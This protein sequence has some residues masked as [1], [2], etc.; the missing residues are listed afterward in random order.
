M[1]TWEVALDAD[2][3]IGLLGTF[4]LVILME[5]DVWARLLETARRGAARRC[6][7]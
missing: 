5:D 4:S 3:L 6:S 1:I 2:E 7:A